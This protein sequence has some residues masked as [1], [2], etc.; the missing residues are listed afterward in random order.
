MSRTHSTATGSLAS[1]ISIVIFVQSKILEKNSSKT[2]SF[3]YAETVFSTYSLEVSAK[4]FRDMGLVVWHSFGSAVAQAVRVNS[5]TYV[6]NLG[7][8]KS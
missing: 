7:I 6:F 2:N 3:T 1:I 5:K 8:I 4:T